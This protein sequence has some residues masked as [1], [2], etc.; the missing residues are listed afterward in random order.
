MTGTNILHAL[1]TFI[2]VVV[3]YFF[4]LRS[5]AVEGAESF[6]GKTSKEDRYIFGALACIIQAVLAIVV[7]NTIGSKV[8]KSLLFSCLNFL[9]VLV[10]LLIEYCIFRLFIPRPDPVANGNTPS[11]ELRDSLERIRSTRWQ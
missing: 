6:Y 7:N 9:A 1:S 5:R 11:R 3:L 8:E 4:N 2:I 10:V